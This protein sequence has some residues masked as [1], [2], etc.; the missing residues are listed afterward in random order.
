MFDPIVTKIDPKTQVQFMFDGKS[1]TAAPD[2]SIAAALLAAGHAWFRQTPVS[3]QQRGPFCMMGAC[4]DC[5]VEID[6]ITVQACVTTVTDGLIVTRVPL[7][8]SQEEDST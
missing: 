6:G 2:T 3:G 8:H 1:I 7:M 4:F 5:L